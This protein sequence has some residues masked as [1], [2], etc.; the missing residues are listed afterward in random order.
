LEDYF[1]DIPWGFHYFHESAPARLAFALGLAG[2]RPPQISTACELAFGQGLTLNINAAAD[3][4][5]TWYGTDFNTGHAASAK[6][7]AETSGNGA[8]VFDQ[9]FADFCSRAD[10]PRFDC[11]VLN[12]TWSWISDRDRMILTDFLRDR[13]NPGGAF[14]VHY[15]ALPG[16]ITN[17]EFRNLV[18]D[19]IRGSKASGAEMAA[20]VPVLLDRLRQVVR[21]NLAYMRDHPEID[22]FL[23]SLAA[24][25]PDH[26]AHEY[27]NINWK[28]FRFAEMADLLGGAGLSFAASLVLNDHVDGIHLTS[29]QRDY[30]G[31]LDDTVFREA[32]RDFFLNRGDRTDCWIKAPQALS[33]EQREILLRNLHFIRTR[34]LEE[35]DLLVYGGLGETALSR[36]TVE[37]I[38]EA[39][40]VGVI[41]GMQAILDACPAVRDLNAM[42]GDLALLAGKGL[43]EPL[44]SDHCAGDTEHASCRALNM[45]L[46]QL[47]ACGEDIGTFASP[48][49]AGGFDIA[50]RDRPFL[51]GWLEGARTPAAL[52]GPAEAWLAAREGGGKDA[53]KHRGH[54]LLADAEQFLSGTAPVLQA[55]GIV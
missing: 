33:P 30:L 10:L 26:V 1:S 16:A 53:P 13:L 5:P 35:N 34:P 31:G 27:F 44:P 38:V 49:L 14:V 8:M 2:I 37:P 3:S 19:A 40:P 46:A 51:G 48:V 39:M 23:T 20:R 6:L 32:T 9:P 45:A 4:S 28:P 47:A 42:A 25:D 22:D 43:I 54:S 36:G 50:R 17:S 55:L 15:S 7:V 12:G 11:I 29:R 18:L 41:V 24:A 52:A 21:L